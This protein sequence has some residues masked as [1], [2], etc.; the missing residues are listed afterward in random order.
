MIKNI[1][2]KKHGAIILAGGLSSRMGSDK[3]SLEIKGQTLLERLLIIL[4]PLVCETVVM[5]APGQSIPRIKEEL[6]TWIK[7]GFDSVSGRGPLQGIVDGLPLLSP[8]IKIIYLLTC[9]LP[10]LTREW[11]QTLKDI[12]TEEY[13]IICTEEEKITNPLLAI[14]RRP[15]LENAENILSIGKRRPLLLW[16]GWRIGILSAPKESPW[17]CK[18]TNTPE[19]F[20]KAK[21][22]FKNMNNA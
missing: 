17:I 3:A 22:H 15:V 5:R 10:Y 6:K 13:D 21:T 12:L 18:D 20:E 14:Y 11:L 19:E 9:D 4:R 8:D 2:K 1:T 16:K 7:V